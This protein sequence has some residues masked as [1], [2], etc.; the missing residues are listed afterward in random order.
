MKKKLLTVL[1]IAISMIVSAQWSNDPA[2]N[3]RITPLETEI[4][5]FDIKVSKTGTSFITFNH[6]KNGNTATFL[7]VVDVNGNMLFPEEGL[8]VSNET[9]LSWTLA[10]ELLF[11]DD[12]GNA[13]IVV[14]DCRNS[15]GYDI[16]YTLY[17]VSPTGE[18]LW[19]ENGLDLSGGM[20]HELVA[21]MKIVQLEDGSYVCAWSIYQ[22]NDGYI[23]LQR[24][25]KAG[26]LLWNEVDARI[27]EN[28]TMIEYPYLVNAG[29]NQVI[30]VF[31]RGSIFNR[32]IKA[33]KI[34]NNGNNVWEQD[35]NVYSSGGF[36]FTPLWV[37]LRV[38]PDQ[39]GGAFVGWFDDRDMTWTE[40]TYIAHVKADGT[41]GFPTGELGEKIG[42]SHLRSFF[43]EMYFDKEEGF[44][45]VAWRE[46]NDTQ[47]WQQMKGQKMKV[48]SG[49]LMWGNNGKDI[50]P[51]TQNHAAAF[52]SIQ[53]GGNDNVAIFFSTN[54]WDPEHL[55]LWDVNKV[56]LLNSQGEFVWNEEIIE[57]SNPVSFKGN[58]VSTP[59]IFNNYWLTLWGDERETEGDPNGNKKVYMQRINK[60]GT[61]GASDIQPCESPVNL[62]ATEITTTSA[63]LSWE[64]GNE[65][66]LNWELRYS[67]AAHISW[68]YVDAL[69]EKTY[70]LDGLIPNT[71]YLWTVRAHCTGDQISDWAMQN[72][73]T[74]EPWSVNDIDKRMMTVY[75][76][77]KMINIINPENR[78]IEKVQL[79]DIT[80]KL[81][82]DYVVK[83]TDNVLV[84]TT[85]SSEMIVFVKIIGRN[86]FENHKVLMK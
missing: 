38:I 54:T 48:P 74:T 44:L 55:W 1:M 22:G 45:Y 85:L 83:S 5:D 67:E 52:Y 66:N 58:L 34:D 43:P 57:F 50:Y 13:I 56:T 39:M 4:Y 3:N 15:S 60:D 35:M 16:S 68:I 76:S 37:I 82:F 8:L 51:L 72:E 25:S 80:G 36:G 19:G 78:Y 11:V 70:F 12:D 69:E 17:K 9:T 2:E 63:K 28:S 30:V 81:L 20:A 73:F 23:Q 79:F 75:A 10:G 26:E 77:G 46:T 32:I 6:P 41:H 42:H 14:T 65:A 84:S 31:A 64:E 40:S 62:N 47:S 71:V 61:L 24:I 59:L 7:Q 29:N 33:R 86:E 49:E 18:M 53:S 21:N 27:Y